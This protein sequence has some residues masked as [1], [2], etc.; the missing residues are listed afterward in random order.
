MWFF[1]YDTGCISLVHYFNFRKL[2]ENIFIGKW[3][4]AEAK[5][6]DIVK[7]SHVSIVIIDSNTQA[8]GAVQSRIRLIG[9]QSYFS[10]TLLFSYFGTS[11]CCKFKHN[12][13]THVSQSVCPSE[14]CHIQNQE[15][16]N[17]QSSYLKTTAT[18]SFAS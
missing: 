12:I 1:C 18:R 3:L 16:A 6:S 14:I 9:F 4:F 15:T 17:S 5:R 10:H 2:Q 11:M 13:K 7:R 8:I